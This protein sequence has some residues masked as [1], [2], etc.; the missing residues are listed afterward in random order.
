MEES[1]AN[2]NAITLPE[3]FQEYEIQLPEISGDHFFEDEEEEMLT[4]NPIR[5]KEMIS[6]SQPEL[7]QTLPE[8]QEESLPN[9]LLSQ[10]DFLEIDTARELEYFQEPDYLATPDLS[11]E[12][13]MEPIS[14]LQLEPVEHELDESIGPIEESMELQ[15]SYSESMEPIIPEVFTRPKRK[16]PTLFDPETQLSSEFILKRQNEPDMF[17]REIEEPP[18]SKRALLQREREMTSPDELFSMPNVDNLPK[19]LLKLYTDSM[20]HI[21]LSELD[22]ARHEESIDVARRDQMS[23]A[24]MESDQLSFGAPPSLAKEEE[25]G[26]IGEH[27]VGEEAFEIPEVSH[28]ESEEI[29]EE[30][31]RPVRPSEVE[32]TM[33]SERSQRMLAYLKRNTQE[34]NKLKF[35]SLF[36]GNKKRTV[37]ISFWTLLEMKSK[38]YV[39]VNQEEPYGDIEVTVL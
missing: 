22:L 13:G 3:A 38:N 19:G 33:L 1:V 15:E 17:L 35:Q 30:P 8:S 31:I 20:S 27:L 5:R 9:L 24:T 39:D 7:S 10:D 32:E 28:E 34:D 23:E 14:E 37:A 12:E 2:L 36:E 26:L 29:S 16:Q 18:S 21:R 11:R 4:L 25:L 6:I